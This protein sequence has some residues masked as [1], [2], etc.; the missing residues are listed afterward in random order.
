MSVHQPVHQ[1]YLKELEIRGFQSD[2]AQLRAIDALERCASEWAA[3]KE[4]RSNAL[5]K[6][7]HPAW[8]IYVWWGGAWQKLFDGLLF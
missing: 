2:P 6:L 5:K 3:Y 4:K 1:N 7:G 8:R